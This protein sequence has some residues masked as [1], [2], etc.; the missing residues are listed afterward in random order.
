MQIRNLV[1][2]ISVQERLSQ[3]VKQANQQ[4]IYFCNHKANNIL[5]FALNFDQM[6]RYLLE[7]KNR[8]CE[9][10]EFVSEI[11]RNSKYRSKS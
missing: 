5:A 3:V 9:M 10:T 8:I 2:E 6:P 7:G 1:S 11:G 4:M